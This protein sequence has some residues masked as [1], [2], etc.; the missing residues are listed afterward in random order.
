[1]ASLHHKAKR[2]LRHFEH[3]YCANDVSLSCGL[4]IAGM[5]E[6]S[7]GCVVP[8]LKNFTEGYFN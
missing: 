8:I 6:D 1:M 5:M 3:L 2:N 4:R 7:M